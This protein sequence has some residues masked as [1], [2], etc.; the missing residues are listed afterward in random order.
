MTISKA[1]NMALRGLSIIFIVLH[2]VLHILC[3]VKENEF[4]FSKQNVD[5]FLRLFPEAP[6]DYSLSFFGWLGVSVFIFLSGYGLSVKYQRKNYPSFSWIKNHY[7]KL[8]LLLLPGLF[9]Y[10]FFLDGGFSIASIKFFVR[11]QSLL[12]NLIRPENIRPGIYWYVGLAFQLYVCFMILNKLNSKAL[13]FIFLL[14]SLILAFSPDD[15][16]F[17]MRHNFPGWLPEF[18]FGMLFFRIRDLKISITY[19]ISIS[20]IS[21]LLIFVTSLFRPSFFLAG[22]F[23][24]LICLNFKDIMCR[25]RVLQWLGG[26]SAGLYVIHAVIRGVWFKYGQEIVVVSPL[27]A[28]LIVLAFSVLFA[29]P[30]MFYYKN[31]CNWLLTRFDYGKRKENQCC[32]DP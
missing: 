28:S 19:R 23:F 8:F 3:P 22:L 20:F 26:I 9:F 24:V 29:I 17:Y 1:D 7:L 32:Q 30:Y 31:V 11:E 25:S 13:L 10:V 12:L 27:V 6:F 16:L 4:Y 15:L 5:T 14:S 18:I 21:L 2:N